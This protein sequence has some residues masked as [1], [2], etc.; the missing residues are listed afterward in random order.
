MYRN[1]Y[2]KINES[3][4]TNNI[5]EIKKKYS[6]YKYYIGVV[7]G[8]AYGHGAYSVSALIKGG[9]NYLAVSSLEE[10]IEIRKYEK[11]I[12]ILCLE[13][14][15]SKYIDD[16][17]KYNVTATIDSLELAKEYCKHEK[18]LKVHIKLDTGMSRLGIN[19]SEELRDTI[20]I[21]KENNIE[22]EG[23]YTH[24]ATTG[25]SD[26][27]YDL[28][29]KK[30]VK[31]MYMIDLSQFKIIHLG[32]SLTLVNHQQLPFINGIR[33]GIIM[34]GFNGSM[35]AGK[36]F[37]NYLRELKR[38][39]LIRKYHISPTIR[40]ND[41]NLKTAFSLYTEVM[42]IRKIKKGDFVGYG[43]KY[44]A[45]RDMLIATLPIGYAD[46]MS[47]LIKNVVINGKKYPIVGEICMDMTMI[48]VDESVKLHD[49]V[50]IFGDKISIRE[51][52]RKLNTN[53]Y[54]VFTGITVRVPRIYEDGI[55]IKY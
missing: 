2:V 46:G 11:D 24:F 55:E 49:Q 34:Y 32:R 10:A 21:L 39:R 25:I 5:K 50:E 53:A 13:P 19:D 12:P 40:E 8:N 37:K 4:L 14:I 15:N 23:I 16:I 52:G 22:I 3:T 9:I 44:I 42:S 1:T 47:V 51:V 54:H 43:A 6:N 26:P 31:L 45:D 33:L 35:P 30:F 41:L 36:G 17:I 27:Y 7:K 20:K 18:N 48:E 29:L 28:Q 38:K